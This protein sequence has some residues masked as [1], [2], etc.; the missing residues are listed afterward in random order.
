MADKTLLNIDEQIAYLKDK[1]IEFEYCHEKEARE[2]LLYNNYYFKLTS[3]RKNYEKCREG[4]NAGRYLFL[5]FAY[6]KDLAI[7]DMRFRKLALALSIDLEHYVKHKILRKAEEAGEDGYKIVKEFRASME[8]NQ[9]NYFDKEMERSKQSIYCEDLYH[10]YENNMSLWGM[11]ELI[12]FGRV[13]SL[14]LFC[15]KRFSKEKG[16]LDEAYMLRSC[17]KLRNAAA[18]NNCI[19]NELRPRNRKQEPNRTV[20]QK[21]RLDSIRGYK[22]RMT[23]ERMIHIVTL[24]FLYKQMITSKGLLAHATTKLHEFRLRMMQN[25]MYYEKNPM[26]KANLEFLNEVIEK[27]FPLLERENVPETLYSVGKS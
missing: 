5:D 21:L 7:I 12:P 23:N 25:S 15:A 24:L 1:G 6:L 3:Y 4:K 14:Y 8:P 22:R 19:F 11:L 20:M 9:Q 2:Y 10:K 16:M 27:W 13:A 18:H 17:Q 26:I